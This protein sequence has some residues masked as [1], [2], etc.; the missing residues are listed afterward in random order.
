MAVT[1]NTA[2]HN[3]QRRIAAA[4][5]VWRARRRVS[6]LWTVA[7][8]IIAAIMLLP[9]LGVASLALGGSGDLW[10][11]LISTVLPAAIV[12]TL[13][14]MLGVGLATLVMGAG[15]AW[16][17]TMFRFPARDAIVW[18]L[19]VPLAMP[20]YIVAYCYGDL[21]D[22]TGPLQTAVRFLTGA[23]HAN[24][25]WFPAVKSLPGAVFV[26]SSVLYP[27]VYLSA[28]ASFLQQSAGP[29]EVARTLGH[30][31]TGVFWRVALPMARPALVAGV[32]LAMMECLNDVGAVQYL[33]V[34]TLT[35]TAYAT[36]L[37][38]SSLA[39]AAQISLVMLLFVLTLFLAER[40]LRGNRGFHDK[41]GRARPSPEVALSGWRAAAATFVCVLPFLAG[42]VL[43]MLAL[44]R[45]ALASWQDVTNTAFVKAALT[46]LGVSLLAA[47]VTGVFA[48][49][50]AYA[51]R[52]AP[53][54]LTRPAMRLASL[55]YAIPGT[56][57]ALGLIWPLSRF[58][59]WFAGVVKALT[60]VSPGLILSGS[61]VIVVLAYVIRFMS[62]SLGAIESGLTRISPNLDAAARTLGQTAIGS[63]WRVHLPLL[64]PPFG[65]ALLLVFVDCMKELP[66]TLLLR[67]F[68]FE[69]LATRVYGLAALDQFE[70]AALASLMIVLVGMVPLVLLNRA[71]TGPMW[72]LRQ[73]S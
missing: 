30:T 27:Y 25:Y 24:D 11:H 9:V 16:L 40:A 42:F 13:S 1:T 10:P 32:A 37:Q 56:V 63:L 33:G 71:M 53:N 28:R 70:E 36:W 26:L 20:T 52:V 47:L 68:N 72:P 4:L 54:G 39:G 50:F 7:V 49:L 15:T 64:R 73:K 22:F 18:L 19:L 66:A 55:G 62:V 2:P 61:V 43:P 38:R 3:F 60:G 14:L 31:L 58:D 41:A 6:P 69:T 29:L 48:L 46:S 59:N 5:A 45:G 65:A 21:F 34:P 44:L 57:L 67:P 8:G 51:R 35:A 17:V 12:R 23:K